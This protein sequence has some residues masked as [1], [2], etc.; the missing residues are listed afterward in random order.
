MKQCPKC[1]KTYTDP[2]LNFCLDDGELLLQ[3]SSGADID[4]A[5]PTVMLNES[6]VTNPAGWTGQ[7]QQTYGQA[8]I[9]YQQP[10]MYVPAGQFGPSQTL[11]IVS[12][13]LGIASVTIGWCCSLGIILGPAAGI[14]GF[15]AMSQANKDPQHHGGKGL[16]IGGIV[17]G[18][19]ATIGC[20][21]LLLFGMLSG[22]LGK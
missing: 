2:Q 1:G 10:Q 7:A 18:I 20:A 14:T 9:P 19:I 21:I 13:V 16:A 22:L 8:P 15:I 11:A 3:S 17:T 6:R 12:L 4:D 5:P